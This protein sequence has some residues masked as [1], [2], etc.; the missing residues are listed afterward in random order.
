ML[1]VVPLALPSVVMVRAAASAQGAFSSVWARTDQP[2][3]QGTASRTWFWGPKP[4]TGII[5]ERYLDAPGG[6]RPVQYYDKGRMELTDPAAD[7]SSEWYVTSGLLTREL[8]SG[9][10]QIGTAIYL[11]AD[12]GAAIPIAGD[13]DN[14]FPDYRDLAGIIDRG[15]PDRTGQFATGALLQ[16]GQT[17]RPA[18]AADPNARFVHYVGYTGPSG[19]P[20]GYNIPAAFWQFMTQPGLIERAGGGGTETAAPLDDW[21]F[22]LGYPIADPFWTQVRVKG[23]EQWV[24][25]QPFERRVLTYTPSN[26][27]GWQ[28]EMGNIGQHYEEWRY[29]SAPP[30]TVNGDVAYM[31][32]RTGDTWSYGVTDGT[33]EQWTMTGTSVAFSGGSTLLARAEEGSSGNFITYWSVTPG[34]LDLYGQDRLD[35]NGKLVDSTVYWPPINELPAGQLAS[36]MSWTTKGT[37]LSIALPAYHFVVTVTVGSYQLVSTPAGYFPAWQLSVSVSDTAADGPNDTARLA[38]VYWFSP[39]IGIIQWI[40]GHVAGQLTAAT[41]V[42]AQQ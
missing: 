34:G 23:I 2:V 14:P 18:A 39:D 4:L 38:G 13:P 8:I 24:L 19:G 5:Q 31:A 6:T 15:Q 32:M 3:A 40:D 30:A 21:L 12:G 17:T 42:P 33:D 22:V 7:P 25:V 26:P 9:R 11:N 41:T 10:I 35:A 36:G 29:G 27:A 1:L 37:A 16:S 28:V 20:V